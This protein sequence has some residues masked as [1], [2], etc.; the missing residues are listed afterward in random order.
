MQR[1]YARLANNKTK[2]KNTNAQ[3]LRLNINEE[4]II[5][6]VAAKFMAGAFIYFFYFA[7]K[8]SIA[9]HYCL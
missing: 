4:T 9:M 7:K 2:P 8:P 6:K 1:A 3:T 5:I